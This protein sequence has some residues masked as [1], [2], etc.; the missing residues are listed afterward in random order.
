MRGTNIWERAKH[1]ELRRYCD[2]LATGASK[3]VSA[4]AAGEALREAD[5]ADGVMPG[6]AAPLVLKGR[7]LAKLGRFGEA[8]GAFAEARRRDARSLDDSAALLAF[9]RAC[10]RSNHEQEAVAS[11]RALLP[12]A[13]G[14]SS[15]ERAGAYVEAAMHTMNAGAG[16]LEDSIAMLRQARREA[17][18]ALQPVATLALALALDRSGDRDEA[19]AVLDDRARAAARTIARDATVQS[20]LG[21]LG[22]ESHALAAIGLDGP[23]AQAAWQ[24]F[25]AAAPSSPWVDHAKSHLGAAPRAP[26]HR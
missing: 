13:D 20:L 23:E 9:A 18:D 15:N 26:R 12:R 22:F 14:L 19:R 24:A 7:A 17:T 25:I 1:P 8:Y 6:H 5:E 21:P 2:L 16:S 10:A 4:A 11:F 3:L